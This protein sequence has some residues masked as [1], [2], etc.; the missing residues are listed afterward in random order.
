MKTTRRLEQK[1]IIS[2]KDYYYLKNM[3]SS[4]LIH[5]VHNEKEAYFVNSI[6]FDDIVYTGV[7][8]KVFG[9][10]YHKKYRIRYYN[11]EKIKKLE[12]KEKVAEVS[13]KYTSTIDDETFHAIL[14]KNIDVLENK[15]QDSLIRRFT[16]DMLLNHLSP[17]CFI[18]YK[19]EAYKDHDNNV[20]ITFDFSLDGARYDIEEMGVLLPLLE[21][22]KIILEIKYETYLPKELKTVLNKVNINQISYSKYL[23]GYNAINA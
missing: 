16:L 17:T 19:R 2:Y 12:L 6:Y 5:D 8:D 22:H 18:S 3:I 21:Q 11:N 14:H 7:S 23:L 20:R 9:N 13:T 10:E 4:L 1:Y 15:F